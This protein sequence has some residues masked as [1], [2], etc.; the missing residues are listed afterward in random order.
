MPNL[1]TI[2]YKPENNI[3][4]TQMHT[5][6]DREQQKYARLYLHGLMC[7]IVI[8]NERVIRRVS[9]LILKVNMCIADVREE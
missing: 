1:T 8:K 5:L 7:E 2:L 9:T 3:F 6:L 4:C